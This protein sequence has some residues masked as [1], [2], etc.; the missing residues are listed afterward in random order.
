MDFKKNDKRFNSAILTCKLDLH[1]CDAYNDV[2]C[3]L[4]S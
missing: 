4:K 2:S 3:V 1:L